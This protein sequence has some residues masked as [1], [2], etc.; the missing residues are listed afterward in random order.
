MTGTAIRFFS[1]VVVGSAAFRS[2]RRSATRRLRAA[3]FALPLRGVN[4]ANGANP[5]AIVVPC[6]PVLGAGGAPHPLRWRPRAQEKTFGARRDRQR[7]PLLA[8]SGTP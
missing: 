2:D 6:H 4:L 5:I 1:D 7:P 8:S 3:S